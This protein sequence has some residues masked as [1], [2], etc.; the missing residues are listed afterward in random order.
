MKRDKHI[1]IGLDLHK[2]QHTAVIL[3]CWFEKLG[4]MTFQNK[5]SIF[6]SL[7]EYVNRFLTEDL[8]PVFG[9]E[10][11]GGYG[12][13][14]ALY[15]L[16][17]GYIVKFVNSVN[18]SLSNAERNSYAM[19]EKN[20][21]WDAQCVADVLIRKLPYLPDATPSDIHWIIA[22]LVGRRTALVKA[23]TALKNQLHMQL[24]YHY[25]SYKDFFSEV[26]GKTALS[27]WESYPSPSHLEG[28]TVEGLREFL[29]EASNNACS[30]KKAELILSLVQADGEVKREY[31][32]SRD[33]II[34]SM[35]R[36]IRFKKQEIKKVEKEIKV[37]IKTLGMQ[38][39][40]M[41]G[42]DTVT[43][44]ALNAEIGDI[45]RF[46]N[47]DKLARY[48][49][50]APIR[51]GSGGKETMKKTKQG[52]RKLYDIFYNLSVQQVQVC[53]G[54]KI[55][56]NPVFYDYYNCKLSEG[57]SK[58]QALLCIMRRLVRIIYGM[59][60]NKTAYIL[61]KMPETIAS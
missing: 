9:L 53:K 50:I 40:T 58:S 19:T 44:S 13:D 6:P 45:H 24:N 52:N 26:D 36:D 27:F 37:T 57:K 22:Q 41:P 1:Y 61:P 15:L 46:A 49:G 48:A 11:V 21:S 5:P 35:V 55:P 17:K 60:R 23:Q 4:E 29:L 3:D 25:P 7:L 14:L 31:Q 33:F 38:L 54:S 12:R 43:S 10:D 30:T 51:M 59:M 20:D 56:R 16:E 47:S 39:E 18:S 34:Q 28:E 2:F 32:T 8:T 42:I